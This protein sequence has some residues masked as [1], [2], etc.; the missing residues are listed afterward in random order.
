MRHIKVTGTSYANAS[1]NIKHI[2]V[3]SGYWDML[4]PKDVLHTKF[5]IQAEPDNK[6]DPNAL[7]VLCHNPLTKSWFKIGYIAADMTK[8]LKKYDHSTQKGEI[9]IYKDL[10][11]YK[12]SIIL[13][14]D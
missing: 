10:S 5:K 3:R 13:P 12:F 8:S 11:N 2:L 14:D 1:L 6:V 4:L 7:M 9:N